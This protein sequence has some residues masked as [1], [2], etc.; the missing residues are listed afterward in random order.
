MGHPASPWTTGI[1]KVCRS[2]FSTSTLQGP[3]F[4]VFSNGVPLDHGVPSVC[5]FFSGC[6][7][8]TWHHIPSAK[9][10]H[11]HASLSPSLICNRLLSSYT[12]WT[13]PKVNHN[14]CH[15][16]HMVTW[17]GMNGWWWMTIPGN[18]FPEWIDDKIPHGLGVYSNLWLPW[19][20]LIHQNPI[21][22]P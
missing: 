16:W 10:C 22:V 3:H 8:E 11:H 17:H 13:T 19:L 15:V 4:I 6:W 2:A 12:A 1:H 7:E 20:A 21:E 9:I 18:L 5:L 14:G